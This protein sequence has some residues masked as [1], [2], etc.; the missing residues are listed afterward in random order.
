MNV[1]LFW[2]SIHHAHVRRSNCK[3]VY[4]M[5][6]TIAVTTNKNHCDILRDFLRKLQIFLAAK[7]FNAFENM[8][9]QIFA[10]K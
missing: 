9:L 6:M 2:L 7:F 4:K 8:K 1:N 5:S 3:S 10:A